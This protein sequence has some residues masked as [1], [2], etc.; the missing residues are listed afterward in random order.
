MSPWHGRHEPL[1]ARTAAIAARHVG[2]RTGFVD[3]DQTF[4]VQVRLAGTP[5][6][7]S[8][9]DIRPFLFGGSLRLFLSGSSRNLSLFHRQPML[10]L[11][12]RS[13]ASHTCSSSSVASGWAATRARRASS[14]GASFGLGPPPERRAV[15][16]PV[17]RRR[18]K[19][20]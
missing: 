14:C 13:T 9:G 10:T 19:A 11:I 8:L 1:T 20:L 15:T 17:V 12:S 18:I 7:A 4:R 2:R 5:L 3:E 6:I 16:S